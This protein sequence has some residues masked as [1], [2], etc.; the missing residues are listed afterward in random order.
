MSARKPKSVPWIG[1]VLLIV[2][3]GGYVGAY[4]RTVRKGMYSG[5][6]LPPFPRYSMGPRF[7]WFFRPAHWVDRR[8]RPN[9]WSSKELP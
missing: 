7:D 6:P 3:I 8:L 2:L 9:Y 5:M 1:I 4:Y